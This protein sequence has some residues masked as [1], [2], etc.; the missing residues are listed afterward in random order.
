MTNTFIETLKNETFTEN[1]AV[2]KIST[3]NTLVDFFFHAPALRVANNFEK[4]LDLFKASFHFN[5]ELTLRSLFYIRDCRGGQGERRIFRM[6][7]EWLAENI[8]FYRAVVTSVFQVAVLGE[9]PF[10]VEQVYF[11]I[12]APVMVYCSHFDM[13]VHL[14][15]FNEIRTSECSADGVQQR[16][17]LLGVNFP[18]SVPQAKRTAYHTVCVVF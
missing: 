6:C 14:L 9:Q 4:V 10:I 12:V 15:D 13:S 5:K 17:K 1:G 2:T 16:R 7:L 8:T 11:K 18:T 3:Q